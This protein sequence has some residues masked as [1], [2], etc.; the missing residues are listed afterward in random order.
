VRNKI[1]YNIGVVGIM[2]NI[3]V[4]VTTSVLVVIVST[5]LKQDATLA[6]IIVGC[7]ILVSTTLMIIILFVPKVSWWYREWG[8]IGNGV[9]RLILIYHH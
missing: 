6:Y 9:K 1:N 3:Y 7:L 4:V 5:F 8:Y 2:L